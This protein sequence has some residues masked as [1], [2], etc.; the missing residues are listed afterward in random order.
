M[1][2]Y[3]PSYVA[4]NLIKLGENYNSLCSILS[5]GVN[6][7]A[8][9]KANAYGLGAAK[10]SSYLQTLGCND[11]FVNNIDEALQ[12]SPPLAKCNVYILSGISN[13]EVNE[14]LKHNF[15]A[16]ISN[17]AQLE[18]AAKYSIK[19]CLK[20]NTGMGRLG[21]KPS[22]AERLRNKV[23]SNNNLCYIIS[24]L[25]NAENIEDGY[26][27]LQLQRFR[28]IM[29]YF[30]KVKA[31]LSNSAGVMLG[32]AYH[33]QLVRPGAY[34]YG[35]C[36][37]NKLIK[38]QQQVVSSYAK[39]IHRYI[40]ED[41]E[42]ISYDKTYMAL[43]GHKVLVV[44]IGYADGYLRSNSNKS[45]MYAYNKKL[46]VI[47]NVTMDMTMLNAS[48]LTETEFA[49]CN[50]VEVFGDNVKVAEIAAINNT[51]SY[52]ILTS[53]GTRFNKKYIV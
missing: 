37:A 27:A 11:F 15:I 24:H 19:F 14:F 12:I 8:V 34:L 46:P 42:Y 39:V 45:F 13:R 53:I 47:G 16:V 4:I 17:D 2:K 9:V 49:E 41:E 6:I 48:Q 5:K 43:K 30:P 26:S 22:D 50:F 52:E 23:L 31:S 29:H 32:A 28:H 3:L 20:F 33:Y 51:I 40:A 1:T 7:A 36:T 44:Q 18:I 10:V 21:F 38:Q 25:S 35:I